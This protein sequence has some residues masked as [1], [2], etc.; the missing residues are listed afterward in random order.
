MRFAADRDDAFIEL[1]YEI[2]TH[3]EFSFDRRELAKYSYTPQG[4]VTTEAEQ[5]AIRTLALELLQGKR[6]M[7][8]VLPT[9]PNRWQVSTASIEQI[10]VSCRVPACASPN[11]FSCPMY[12]TRAQRYGSTLA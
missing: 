6:P 7:P 5:N 10:A 8:V 12:R 3:L 9:K 2:G 11:A 1:M 4:W